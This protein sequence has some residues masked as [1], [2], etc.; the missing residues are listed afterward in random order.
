MKAK[1][2]EENLDVCA[3]GFHMGQKLLRKTDM[4]QAFYP[5][6]Y[7]N[8]YS[9]EMF[10]GRP[11]VFHTIEVEGTR[12]IGVH[13]V[14]GVATMD[15]REIPAKDLALQCADHART[16]FGWDKDRE[17]IRGDIDWH[18]ERGWL[19]SSYLLF[20]LDKE[21]L[22]KGY[23]KSYLVVYRHE[24]KLCF[25]FANRPSSVHLD[26]LETTARKLSGV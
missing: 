1:K 16:V 26:N 15:T 12:S 17:V 8:P 5:G 7:D 6:G 21:D 4:G 2:E 25:E 23:S 13:T 18:M 20:D 19:S 11:G 10:S 3:F 9:V 24:M 14:R 22:P